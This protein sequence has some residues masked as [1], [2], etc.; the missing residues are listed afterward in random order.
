MKTLIEVVMHNS[1]T[2]PNQIAI[3]YKNESITYRQLYDKVELISGYLRTLK[4]GTGSCIVLEAV[5]KPEYIFT[6]L[7]IQMAGGITVP[8]E[9]AP[10]PEI[11]SYIYQLTDAKLYI[12]SSAR[13]P[14]GITVRS[15]QDIFDGANELNMKGVYIPPDFEQVCEL[16]FTT[17]TTGKPKGTMHTYKGIECSMENTWHGIGM[18]ETDVI[19]LPL[20]LNHSFGMRVLRSALL[21]G[22][23]VV[24]Q[25]GAIFAK[26]TEKNIMNYSCTAMVCIST[27][28]E[29]MIR[30]MGTEHAKEVFGKLRYIEFS[31]GAVSYDLRNRLLKML[32][33]T[34]IHN[35][36]GSSE[37]GGCLFINIS[38]HPE[39]LK[40]MGKPLDTLQVRLLNEDNKVLNGYGPDVIGKLSLKGDMQ[41]IGYWGKP[42]I[43]KEVIQD[44]WLVMNDLVWR[45]EDGYLY[46]VGRADDII[47]IG[48]EKLSPIEVED[49]TNKY[50]GVKESACIGVK[51]T[52]GHLGE[53]PILYL[54][55]EDTSGKNFDTNL[56]K[57]EMAQK[58]TSYKI[59]QKFIYIDQLPRNAMGKIERKKL[60]EMW[61]KSRSQNQSNPV[62]KAI[63]ERRSIRDFTE[64]SIQP[65][66]INR[67]LEAG[68]N[69]PSGKNLQTRRFTVIQSENEIQYLKEITEKVAMRERASFHG[70][71]NPKALILV[72]NDRRNQDGIQDASCSAE[73]IMLAASSYGLGSVW[74]NSLMTICDEIEIREKLNEYEIPANHIVWAMIAVGWPE[75]PGVPP[76]R[77]GNVVHF[78]N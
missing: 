69:A 12:A 39:K 75:K 67:M 28:M 32:P 65:E 70:F 22:A 49:I 47:N 25:N 8:V 78:V 64:K 54:C 5:S 71:H 66:M 60:L 43:T 23:S 52:E 10:K 42:E 20:P 1:Q 53:I 63:L 4:I 30:Q 24:L 31:A 26:E 50:P 3:Y 57:Q 55:L 35:T 16:I 21:I 62:L 2:K 14:E 41:M 7:A 77:K 34:E 44:G 19:L 37:S 18:Q 51:D 72:S 29:M 68:I 36:W 58:L 27:A 61:E 17:G 40:S 13:A 56:L 59:P 11:L 46:M 38:E 33:E 6:V 73:N 76:E 74:L 45:D 9:R 48:G 15:Y